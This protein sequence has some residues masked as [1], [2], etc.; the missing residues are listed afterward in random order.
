MDVA[1]PSGFVHGMID[2]SA[3][4][5]GN[6][7]GAGKGRDIVQ[8]TRAEAGRPGQ[9][10]G[11][12]QCC[13]SIRLLQMLPYCG[14]SRVYEYRYGISESC[15]SSNIGESVTIIISFESMRY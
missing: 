14:I 15:L 8:E 9:T 6:A 4:L 2:V 5:G 11:T 1:H 10:A 12:K 7:Y 3:A 13:N